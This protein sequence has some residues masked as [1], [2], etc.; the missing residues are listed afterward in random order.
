MRSPAQVWARLIGA[1]LVIAGIVGFFY[2]AAFGSPGKVDAVFGV[3]DVNGWH[4]LLHIASGV[5]GLAL[6]RS[7]SSARFY[8]LLLAA[9]Y[10]VVAIW[11]FIVGDGGAILGFLP[12]NTEDN[13]LHTIIAVVSLAVGIGTPEVPAPSEHYAGHQ[14]GPKELRR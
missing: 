6:A 3:L 10:V 2:S 12:V 4:N 14:Y 11:G 13:V 7:Y 9:A 5:L 1:V 8:C